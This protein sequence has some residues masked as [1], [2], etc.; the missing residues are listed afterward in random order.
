MKNYEYKVFPA[1]FT[2]DDNDREGK[3]IALASKNFGY[4]DEPVYV[5][6]VDG[7]L[8]LIQGEYEAP[9]KG[10]NINESAE[11]HITELVKQDEL[12]ESAT[13]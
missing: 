11:N 1:N 12:T 7:N 9:Y 6:Y 5:I 8:Q 4:E 2:P 10:R 13:A 3:R